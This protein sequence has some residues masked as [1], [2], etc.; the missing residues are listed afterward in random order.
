MKQRKSL[1]LLL[2]VAALAL[3]APG[4][5]TKDVNPP[6]A[7]A[8]MGYVDF[9]APADEE[10]SWQVG[11]FDD[12]TKT[13]KLLYLEYEPPADGILRLALKPGH[14]R[15]QVTI[16]NRVTSAPAVVEVEIQ[17]GLITPVAFALTAEGVAKVQSRDEGMRNSVKGRYAWKTKYGTKESITFQVATQVGAPISYKAKEW[18]AYAD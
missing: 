17:D 8:H 7:R 4:C 14:Y 13:F 18:M 16:V 1:Q 10:L 15:F 3:L 6:Q 12:Q 9:H 11:C 5:A 2:A